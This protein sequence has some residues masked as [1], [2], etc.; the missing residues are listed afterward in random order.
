AACET[1]GYTRGELIKKKFIELIFPDDIPKAWGN[2]RKVVETGRES[3]EIRFVTRNGEIRWWIVKAIRLNAV[4]ILAT[5][6]DITNRKAA[7]EALRTANKKLQILSGIT[8]HDINN[9]IMALE[10]YLDLIRSEIEQPGLSG[11]LSKAEKAAATIKKQIE[12]T[13]IYENL[14]LHTPTWQSLSAIIE[15]IDDSRIPIH[16]DCKGFS[17]YADPM[18]EKVLSNLYD[19]TRRHGEGAD[20]VMIRC[21][22][23]D[24]N[25]L[26]TWEDNGPGVS[27][28]QKERIFTKGFGKNTGF[29]LFLSREI[30]GIT[31]MTIREIGEE[32]KGARFEIT[33][34]HGMWQYTG[35]S[36]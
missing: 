31:G 7:E 32:G 27:D 5:T 6:N 29:G 12:F 22:E 9:Q 34:P 4:R 14:G 3:A 20:D 15:A 30:L 36:Q 10:G 24:G 17:V 8:R 2:F 23:Q 33:V 26:I 18:F 1:T 21:F 25:L 16:H 28:D 35:E 11:H 13:K 19:N